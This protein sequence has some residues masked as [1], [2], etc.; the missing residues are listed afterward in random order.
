MNTRLDIT[1]NDSQSVKQVVTAYW[2]MI[3][4]CGAYPSVT[5][6][7]EDGTESVLM[8]SE[9][10]QIAQADAFQSSTVKTR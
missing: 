7:Y 2:V 6:K 3:D 5:N 8:D 9:Q 1:Q 4:H 10:D